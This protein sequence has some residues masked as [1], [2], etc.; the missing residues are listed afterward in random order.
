M[1]TRKQIRILAGI[2]ERGE[3]EDFTWDLFP[4]VPAEA[5]LHLNRWG[6]PHPGTEIKEGM[7]LVGK[8]GKSKSFS[9]DQI[10]TALEI[11]AYEFP[12][13]KAKFGHLWV[14]RSV[15]AK[16]ADTGIVIHAKV[17]PIDGR[18]VAVVELEQPD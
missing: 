12:T 2:D 5:T 7:I 8:I 18:E 14:D 10:P 15:Y 13:L 1:P 3:P 4:L 11:H 16:K 9:E 6:V 17:E